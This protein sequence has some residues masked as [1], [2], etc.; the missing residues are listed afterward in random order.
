MPHDL[1]PLFP[2]GTDLALLAD[3]LDLAKELVKEELA[4]STREGY[5]RD[6]KQFSRWCASRNVSPM[7][8]TPA[9]VAAYVAFLVRESQLRGATLSRRMAAIAWVHQI[10]GEPDP[11]TETDQHTRSAVRPLLRAARRRLGTEAVNRKA[12]ITPDM[13]VVMLHL[14]SDTLAG[15]RDRAL[16]S[17]GWAA[18]LRRSELVALNVEDIEQVAGGIHLHI[19]RS[20]TDQEGAGQTIA[21][22]DR[23]RDRIRPAAALRAWLKAAKIKQGPIFLRVNKAGRV[24]DPIDGGS[25]GLVVKKYAA[26]A[27]LDVE[28]LGGHSLR[29]GFATSAAAVGASAS[30]M[31]NVTRHTD[32]NV[33]FGYIRTVNL[34]ADYPAKI[35]R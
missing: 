23:A 28:A 15:K 34:V 20:K 21:V 14:C 13:L 35:L 16:L 10:A 26:L 25:V 4:A 29:A 3:D 19:R 1:T 33:L 7:P 24:Q 30:E 11:T 22:P 17:L 12:A 6:F 18:A 32:I 27:G 5:G 8:A 31:A 2:S 9:V